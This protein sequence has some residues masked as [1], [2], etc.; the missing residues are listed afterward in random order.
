MVLNGD[1]L[2][3]VEQMRYLVEENTNLRQMCIHKWEHEREWDRRHR[4]TIL[5]KC[6]KCGDIQ[7][8]I[9]DY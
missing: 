1:I 7:T 2:A 9:I 8:R 4:L 5:L 3:L 6:T